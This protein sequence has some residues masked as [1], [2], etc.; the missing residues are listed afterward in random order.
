MSLDPGTE[1]Q[2]A[3]VNVLMTHEATGWLRS[4]GTE[5]RRKT[6]GKG[7]NHRVY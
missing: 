4:P 7:S 5:C 6:E 1:V 2:G 3:A